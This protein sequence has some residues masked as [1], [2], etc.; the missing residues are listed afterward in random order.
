MARN[1][2]VKPFRN[3]IHRSKM[4]FSVQRLVKGMKHKE[5]SELTKENGKRGVAK[6]T[7][8]NWYIPVSKGGTCWPTTRCLEAVVAAV[9]GHVAVINADGEEV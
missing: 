9:G 4:I 2:K 5:I 6:E 8:R 1:G 7:I 3:Q